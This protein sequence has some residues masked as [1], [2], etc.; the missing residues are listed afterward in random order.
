MH[1]MII[2][3]LENLS[4]DEC[5]LKSSSP[6]FTTLEE[7]VKQ[8]HSMNAFCFADIVTAIMEYDCFIGKMLTECFYVFIMMAFFLCVNFNEV[9]CHCSSFFN[10]TVPQMHQQFR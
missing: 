8:T 1:T 7:P 3:W 2:K 10:F 4:R 6:S 9:V 5:D